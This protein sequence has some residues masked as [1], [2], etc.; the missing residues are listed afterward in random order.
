[1]SH[2]TL[3]Q[4]E[5]FIACAEL[6]SM[7]AASEQVHLTQSAISTA[8]A[9]FEKSLG[10]QL[11]IR[12][13]RG[14]SLTEAGRRVL[15]DARRLIGSVDD[16]HASAREIGEALTGGLRVGCYST[17][18]PT[19][20][21]R[22]VADF[23]AAHPE[24]EL[25]IIEGSHTSL[26]EELR[27]GRCEL[28]LGYDYQASGMPVPQDLEA[29]IVRSAPPHLVLPSGHKLAGRKRV[30]LRDVVDEPFILFDLAPGGDYFLNMFHQVGLEPNVRFRTQSFETARSLVA[31]GLGY[32]I[33]TQETSVTE[34]YEGRG[35]VT[36]RL[37]DKL[38][39][40]NVVLLQLAAV[41]PTRRAEAFAQQCV[42]SLS[43][44][45]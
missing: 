7:R 27:A 17:L 33:L 16:L 19:L 36:K 22:V 14:I 18:A 39:E 41:R 29:H 13:T 12:H 3:R 45:H 20:L 31:R 2:F 9:D 32:T 8:I 4:L 21:P 15:A 42:Q 38:P 11:L 43:A 1:M 23:T 10:V 40:I 34:S 37:E 25:D 5:Y 24:V 35:I 28:A 6:G 26:E 44:A 30:F